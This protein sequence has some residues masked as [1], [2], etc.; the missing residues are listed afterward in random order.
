MQNLILGKY[1]NLREHKI[2]MTQLNGL[3]TGTTLSRSYWE[4][5]KACLKL[6]LKK[7]LGRTVKV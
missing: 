7:L 3:I 6:P 4:Y 5:P 2:L 1:Q